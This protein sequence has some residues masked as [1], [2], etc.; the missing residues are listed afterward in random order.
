MGTSQSSKGPR[1]GVPLVPP[2][3]PP[4]PPPDTDGDDPPNQADNPELTSSP[5]VAVPV[6]TPGR[7]GSARLSLGGFAQSG[8]SASM[9]RG[10][11]DYVRKGYGGH[12]AA[13]RRFEGTARTAGS[14]YGALSSLSTGA[15]GEFA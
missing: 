2:W 15:P 5:P 10:V 11:S 12:A 7:F 6:A 14:L 3:V 8:D 9:R 1:G 4:P 13:A